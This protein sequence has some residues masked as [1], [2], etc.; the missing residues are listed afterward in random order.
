M[1]GD[2]EGYERNSGRNTEYSQRRAQ[3]A[4]GS[5][6]RAYQGEQSERRRRARAAARRRKQ[7][8]QRRILFA[9][10]VLVLVGIAAAAVIGVR[11]YTRR[12]QQETLRTEGIAAMESQ[13]YQ[14]A[15]TK[16]DEALA[17]AGGKSG[18]LENDILAYRADA[19]YSAKDYEASLAD[20]QKLLEADSENENIQRNIVLCLLETGRYEEALACGVMQ[21]RVYN[22]IVVEQI[23][24]GEYEQ[25]LATIGQGKAASDG[26]AAA[27]LAYNEAVIYEATGDYA[28]AL[29]LFEDYVSRYGADENAEREIT[30]L[31]TRQGE[32]E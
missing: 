6:Q 1:T 12:K 26:E 22:R 24:A 23:E 4:A 16:F 9:V 27:D 29:E 7:R 17:L 28:K 2:V 15:K 19:L 30:F 21:S 3:G 25:A 32:V 8:R 14:T 13:D 5:R 31:K 11:S 20:W 10:L 18:E